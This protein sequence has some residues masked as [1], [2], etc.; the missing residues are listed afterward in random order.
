MRGSVSGIVAG[1]AYVVLEAVDRTSAALNSVRNKIAAWGMQLQSIGASIVTKS[2]MAAIPSAISLKIFSDFDD[3]MKKVEARSSGTAAQLK[4]VRD[5]ARLLGR[6]T[7]FTARQIAELQAVL[8]QRGFTRE[9]ILAMT[10]NIMSLAR[11]G[12]SGNLAQDALNAADLVTN[13]MRAYDMLGE[14]IKNSR[15]AVDLFTYAVNRSNATIEDLQV[16]IGN[17]ASIAETYNLS[18]AESLAIL[19]SMRNI[20]IDPSIAGTGLRNLF[21]KSSDRKQV[22]EFNLLMQEYTGQII[23]FTDASG[24]LKP[25]PDLLFSIFDAM[26]G[27]GT[28]AQGELIADLFGLRAIIP[29]AGVMKARD[30]FE[31]FL[32]GMSRAK[33]MADITRQLMES[34]IG[35][36]FRMLFSAIEGVAMSLGSVLDKAMQTFNKTITV[37]ANNLSVW[38]E[39]NG[40]LVA[41]LHKILMITLPLGAALFI[42]GTSF[43]LS[44][45]MMAPIVGILSTVTIGMR[46][47]LAQVMSLGA[48]LISMGVGG[49]GA[50]VA[51]FSG[52]VSIL[53]MT[54]TILKVLAA[55]F[56]FLSIGLRLLVRHGIKAIILFRT[57]GKAFEQVIVKL[58]LVPLFK[59]R[60]VFLAVVSTVLKTFGVFT[61]I[62]AIQTTRL[63]LL[64]LAHWGKLIVIKS[65]GLLIGVVLT[66]IGA[67]FSGLASIVT[68]SIGI[69]LGSIMGMVGAIWGFAQVAAGAFISAAK[70]G[71]NTMGPM[72]QTIVA[73][74]NNITDSILSGQWELAWQFVLEGA[75]LLWM[76]FDKWFSVVSIGLAGKLKNAFLD[77]LDEIKV[78]LRTVFGLFPGLHDGLEGLQS[79]NKR[80]SDLKKSIAQANQ[81]SAKKDPAIWAQ[82]ARLNR[83]TMILEDIKK[84]G[85]PD[86]EKVELNAELN[87]EM[88]D[89]FRSI[90]RDTEN[91]NRP[92]GQMNQTLKNPAVI[93]G[94]QK[95]SLE[96][97]RDYYE[98]LRNAEQVAEA[99]DQKKL[100]ALRNIDNNTRQTAASIS[101]LA[102]GGV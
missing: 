36:S 54:G 91:L 34:G 27:L 7:A 77:A 14:P 30:T 68:A 61:K 47:L 83:L 71:Y 4:A 67:A 52:L 44:S 48:L 82:I 84:F 2:L 55:E 49:F 96:A 25:V 70:T 73:L 23:E 33:N 5:Q 92:A 9:Q 16:M 43:K 45:M 37:T 35:G 90:K 29:A 32:D 60:Y 99:L 42:L 12:G 51:T 21:I 41:S 31:F 74:F 93:P 72:L 75:K 79:H 81:E 59:L 50:L 13:A 22:E 17:S 46:F 58:M 87:R 1:K 100:A 97:M 102:F 40:G 78:E 38:I 76:Q 10:P 85:I 20:G 57:M 69:I 101:N 53:R 28:A 26:R 18:L 98:N 80:R 63:I 65:I 3:S 24:N 64:M 6:T 15:L 8:A 94:S 95:G 62:F 88:N 66:T 86:A 39:N 19:M 89:L 56:V 11:A